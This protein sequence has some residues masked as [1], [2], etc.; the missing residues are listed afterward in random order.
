MIDV[1]DAAGVVVVPIRC[2]QS[3]GTNIASRSIAALN[4]D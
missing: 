2:P 1:L 4:A 3:S